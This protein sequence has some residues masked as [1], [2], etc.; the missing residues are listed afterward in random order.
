M[1]MHGSVNSSIL[2]ANAR[3][4]LR[5]NINRVRFELL[6]NRSLNKVLLGIEC[7]HANSVRD[8]NEYLRMIRDDCISEADFMSA[9]QE[10]RECIALLTKYKD[11]AHALLALDWLRQPTEAVA[12]YQLFLIDL[13]SA[14]N[15]FTK[16]AVR[17]L[18][19]KLVPRDVDQYM[20]LGGRPANAEIELRVGRVLEALTMVMEVIPLS[21]NMVLNEI[22]VIFPYYTKPSF[23][24]AGFLSSIFRL[25]V[26]RQEIKQ[27]CF[28]LVLGK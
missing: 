26:I 15:K 5:D 17:L 14:H 21:H 20:W 27:D 10:S 2:K 8:Y 19:A 22:D 28:R 7:N 11:L 24:Y 25:M 3:D 6:A 16:Y 4:A 18:V 12:Q 9:I 23:V 13:L 1:S